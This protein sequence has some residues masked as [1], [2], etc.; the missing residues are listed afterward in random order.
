MESGAYFQK[1]CDTA[2]G[3]DDACGGGGNPGEKLEQGA[4][5]CAVAADDAYYVALLNFEVD[6][7]QGPHVIAV[8]FAGAIVGFAYFQVGVFAA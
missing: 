8:A 3:A 7:L 6:V 4:L 1:T 2:L 5:S